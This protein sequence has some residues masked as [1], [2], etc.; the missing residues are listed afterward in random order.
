MHFRPGASFRGIDNVKFISTFN[1]RNFLDPNIFFYFVSTKILKSIKLKIYLNLTK[2]L[3]E[4]QPGT[5]PEPKSPLIFLLWYW[6]CQGNFN[7]RKI[8]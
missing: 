4:T 1:Y 7:F 3:R 5:N 8:F 6:Q 2:D